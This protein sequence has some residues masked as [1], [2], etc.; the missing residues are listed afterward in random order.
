MRTEEE[1]QEWWKKLY[2]MT[3]KIKERMTLEGTL[4]VGYMPLSYC[5]RGNFFRLVVTCQPP[6]SNAAMDFVIDKIEQ[7][8]ADL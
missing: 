5:N 4:M 8:A 6:P 1:T 3:T 2:E 7:L